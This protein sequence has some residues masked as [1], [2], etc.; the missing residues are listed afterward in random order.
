MMLVAVMLLMSTACGGDNAS[1]EN[2]SSSLDIE[3]ANNDEIDNSSNNS[4]TEA[5][6]DAGALTFWLNRINSYIPSESSS[7]I[8]LFND[9]V[10]IPL[11]L[12]TI[13]ICSAPY[14]LYPNGLSAV[15]ISSISEI[16]TSEELINEKDESKIVTQTQYIDGW[17]DY[18]EVPDNIDNIFIK[19]FSE[20]PL[21]TKQCYE[22]GWWYITSEYPHQIENVLGIDLTAEGK[23]Y[24]ADWDCHVVSE[25]VIDKLGLPDYVLM[26]GSNSN[27]LLNNSGNIYYYLIWENADYV[28][29]L[30][31]S[32]MILLDN[33]SYIYQISNFTYYTPEA[34]NMVSSEFSEVTKVNLSELP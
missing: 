14:A 20:E 1:V 19:N 13:D 2:V 24:N 16:L 34:W 28:I 22:N 33:N 32:E 23:N 27:N 3:I 21:S 6:D 18:D 29:S 4:V 30:L 10:T 26:F 17:V 11:D 15:N 7:V 9:Q 25:A 12:S 5:E 31:C 8:D